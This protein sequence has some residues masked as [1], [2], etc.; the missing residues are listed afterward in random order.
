MTVEREEETQNHVAIKGSGIYGAKRAMA[1][2]FFTEVYSAL[3]IHYLGYD[4]YKVNII[5]NVYLINL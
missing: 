5:Y 1:P 2:P 4:L 3:E